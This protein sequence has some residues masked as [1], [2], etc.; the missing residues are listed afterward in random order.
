MRKF[1]ILLEQAL[2][3]NIVNYIIENIVL[4]IKQLLNEV[5]EGQSALEELLKE[6]PYNMAILY[7]AS[8]FRDRKFGSWR[9]VIEHSCNE[10]EEQIINLIQTNP[11]L[12]KNQQTLLL[13]SLRE[14]I[15]EIRNNLDDIPYLKNAIVKIKNQVRV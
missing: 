8:V 1:D 14:E 11:K 15:Q 2:Q 6:R 3:D 10:I 12:D 4:E 5:G 9:E 7:A 13:N